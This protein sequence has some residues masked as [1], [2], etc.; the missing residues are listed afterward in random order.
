VSGEGMK[1]ARG[2]GGVRQRVETETCAKTTNVF[3]M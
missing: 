2:A 1:R 3:I